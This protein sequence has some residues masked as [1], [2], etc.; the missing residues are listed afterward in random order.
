MEKHFL[1]GYRTGHET[2]Q[3]YV[4]SFISATEYKGGH[5]APVMQVVREEEG[6]AIPRAY[7]SISEVQPLAE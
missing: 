5:V 7:I 3:A 2:G 6:I 4:H 1:T